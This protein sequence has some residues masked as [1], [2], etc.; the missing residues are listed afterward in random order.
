MNR[1]H[2]WFPGGIVIG[3][4]ISK[5]MTDAGMRAITDLGNNDTHRSVCLFLLWTKMDQSCGRR[6]CHLKGKFNGNDISVVPIHFLL[7]GSNRDY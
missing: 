2:M 7:Y 5:F 4:L 6:S 3:S 1:F